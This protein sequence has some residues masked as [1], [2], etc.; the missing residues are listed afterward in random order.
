[1]NTEKNTHQE[2]IIASYILCAAGFLGFAGL[3]RLYNGKIGTGLLWFFTLG[4]FY[5]G[6]L[7]DLALIPG[8]VDEYEQNLRFR[9]GIGNRE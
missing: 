1:M 5:V 6:Q 7:V 8:M 4:F 3:H 2:R 9:K